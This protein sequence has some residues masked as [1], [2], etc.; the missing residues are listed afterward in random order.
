[1]KYSIIIPVYNAERTL[2]RCLD[3]VLR[4]SHDAEIILINDG[5]KDQSG[6]ICE[7]YKSNYSNIVYI[8][9]LNEGV[10]AARNDGLDA[11]QG[12]YVLFVDSDD[13]VVEHFYDLLDSVTE[14]DDV[15]GVCFSLTIIRNNRVV[16][17]ALK[18]W[19]SDNPIH[20]SKKL[21]EGIYK[22][23]IN[24]PCAK[25]YKKEIIDRHN[26]RFPEDISIG[27][28]RL[29]NMNYS[30]YIK[31]L[32]ICSQSSYIVTVENQ[33]SLSRKVRDDLEEQF[34]KSRQKSNCLLSEIDTSTKQGAVLL[35]DFT[36]AINFC[37]LRDV[38]AEA[39]RLRRRQVP[40]FDRLKALDIHCKQINQQNFKLPRDIYCFLI[41]IPVKF[42]LALF[43]DLFA[44]LLNR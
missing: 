44:K 34:A 24:S 32:R 39:K 6:K 42:R 2:S 3:S 17:Q 15:D 35:R 28:D 29:F 37:T 8:D 1:M 21:S 4:D 25:L 13:Y 38:Y 26:L 20:I 40:L 30:L 23:W 27:E 36:N 14:D 10:S 33:N 31:N 19:H 22:K 11:A 43:L 12:K 9:K 5:S 16:H 7:K 41:A 18:E